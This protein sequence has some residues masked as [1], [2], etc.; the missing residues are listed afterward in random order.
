MNFPP[1]NLE[2]SLERHIVVKIVI[3]SCTL[4]AILPFHVDEIMSTWL[5]VLSF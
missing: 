3:T 1:T 4:S 2:I 5:T